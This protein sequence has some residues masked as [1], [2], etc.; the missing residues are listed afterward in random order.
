MMHLLPLESI[1]VLTCCVKNDNVFTN[2][3]FNFCH[4]LI[5]NVMH[6]LTLES[7]I[8]LFSDVKSDT[9]FIYFGIIL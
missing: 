5:E 6:L 9:T 4:V 2:F 3:G 1:F 8:V 7:T